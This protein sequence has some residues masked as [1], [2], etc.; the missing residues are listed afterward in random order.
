M[1]HDPGDA[2]VQSPHQPTGYLTLIARLWIDED[3]T[4]VRGSLID[5]H[6]GAQLPLDLTTLLAFVRS[7]LQHT[8]GQP[9]DEP[10]N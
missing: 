9:M 7:S 3:G 6:T 4:R 8:V 5:S 2:G 10:E 1:P